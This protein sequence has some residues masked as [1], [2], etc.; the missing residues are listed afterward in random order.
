MLSS[1]ESKSH[2]IHCFNKLYSQVSPSNMPHIRGRTH[3]RSKKSRAHSN[4]I[5][6]HMESLLEPTNRSSTL[7]CS[8]RCTC[9][10]KVSS[11]RCGLHR[12]CTLDSQGSGILSVVSLP[13]AR[14]TLAIRSLW[15][16]LSRAHSHEQSH[17]VHS[18]TIW[19]MLLIRCLWAFDATQTHNQV[20]KCQ[21]KLCC[22]S[23]KVNIWALSSPL[24]HTR[25][26]FHLHEWSWPL[27]HHTCRLGTL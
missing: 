25:Y 19:I 21:D 9:S 4:Q 5:S 8:L 3:L 24:R 12:C 20:Y 23:L 27:L 1:I 18:I 6:P 17:L 26:I 15:A 10:T 11:K 14:Q 13:H 16:H 7:E 22:R 2:M